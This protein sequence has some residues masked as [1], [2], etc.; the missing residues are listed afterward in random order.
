MSFDCFL[1]NNARKTF[2]HMY[3]NVLVSLHVNIHIFLRLF[4]A[5]FAAYPF[6]PDK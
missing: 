6:I 4:T 2:V 3:V 5:L 1:Y